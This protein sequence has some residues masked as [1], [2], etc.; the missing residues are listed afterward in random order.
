MAKHRILY[1]KEAFVHGVGETDVDLL[2]IERAD[3]SIVKASGEDLAVI[4]E[5]Y[6]EFLI[7]VERW[8]NWIDIER[9]E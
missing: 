9:N 1:V 6:R 8:S 4:I 3:G 5:D 7:G 2:L